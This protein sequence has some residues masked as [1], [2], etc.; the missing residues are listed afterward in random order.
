MSFRQ[1]IDP[2]KIAG[3]RNDLGSIR[4]SEVSWQIANGGRSR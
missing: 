3:A 4:G 2:I 1:R